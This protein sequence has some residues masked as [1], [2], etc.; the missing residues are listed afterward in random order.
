MLAATGL[1]QD[2]PSIFA[3]NSVAEEIVLYCIV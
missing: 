3:V 1:S 2:F